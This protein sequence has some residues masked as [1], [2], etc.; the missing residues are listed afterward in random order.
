MWTSWIPRWTWWRVIPSS[1][2]FSP[3][4]CLTLTERPPCHA[5]YTCRCFCRWGS[6]TFHL[7]SAL[8]NLAWIRIALAHETA[9]AIRLFFLVARVAVSLVAILALMGLDLL[10]QKMT[11]SVDLSTCPQFFT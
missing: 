8:M 4:P 5:Y 1:P 7:V 2:T 10:L 9:L 6:L 11:V 3:L